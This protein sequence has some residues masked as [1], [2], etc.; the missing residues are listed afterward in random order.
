MITS[1]Q[2]YSALSWC[3][4]VSIATTGVVVVIP[5]MTPLL[6]IWAL[7]DALY[8]APSNGVCSAVG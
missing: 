1:F 7:T 8:C 4:S 2:F 3:G 5:V 6:L